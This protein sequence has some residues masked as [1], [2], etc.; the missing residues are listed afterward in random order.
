MGT[1]QALPMWLATLL[2]L[3][4]PASAVA[5]DVPAVFVHGLASSGATWQAAADRLST[6]VAITPYRP[7]L[8]WRDSFSRRPQPFRTP[9]DRYPV[10]PSPSVTAMAGWFPGNGASRIRQRRHHARH[11]EPGAPLA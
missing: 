2:L 1:K 6:P 3:A 7:S 9:W 11:A 8:N 5:Q 10:P 4:I